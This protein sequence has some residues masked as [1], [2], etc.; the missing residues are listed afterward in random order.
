[1]G[2]SYE[3]TFMKQV[4]NLCTKRQR[5]AP[6]KFSPDEC[7]LTE[8]LTAENEEPQSINEALNGKDANKWKQALEEEYNSLIKNE[9]WEFVPPPE[10]CNIVGSKWVMKVKRDANGH[11]DRH[12]ARLVAQGYSQTHGVDYEEVFSPVAKYSSIR[13][14]LALANKH[15][16]EIHQ[17]D[18]KTAF[19]NGHIEHDI[20]MS[21]PD[22][23]VDPDHPEY[24]CKLRK[25][26]YGLKQSARCWNQTLDS[27]LTKNGYRRSDADNCIYVKSIKDS[28]GFISFVILAVY[29]DDIIPVSNDI[30]MLNAEKEL[31][32]KNFEMTDQGEIHFVLGMTINRDR[33]TPTLYINQHKY[34]ESMLERFGMTNCKPIATPLEATYHQQTDEEEAFDKNLYQQAIGCLTYIS[35]ATRPD[36]SAA[37]GVLSSYMSNPSKEHWNGVK[38]LL[39]YIKGT[40]NYGLKF[41]ANESDG[42]NENGDE[43]YGYSDANWAGDVDSRRSTSGYVFKVANCTVSWS[44]KKQGSV[45]K[46]TTEAEY[47]ALSQATQEAIWMRKL[48]SDIGCKSE[49]P[50]TIYEDN[51][52]A[53]EISKNAK[54]HNRTKHI[55]VRFHF[56]REKVS[57]NEVKVVYL[58]TEDMLA[59]IMTKGLTKKRFQRLRSMLNVCSS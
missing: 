51:Q 31:L 33:E 49:E 30:N 48:L 4:Q 2:A 5:Q 18:V 27:F 22:G 9:T 34:L 7:N 1:M 3:E 16:L 28:N 52:G 35:T 44:S 38:R 24:V 12:K 58:S 8:S 43:L 11:V 40:I 14:L 23:F 17:M 26:L 45:T 53:I 25:S 55:D 59:D 37:V 56:I 32:C 54:F 50:T 57:T 29:V 36:I 39:R 42:L 13:T 20:Y 46:S 41:K 19:L 10:G 6:T 47:V 21:Q 15:D